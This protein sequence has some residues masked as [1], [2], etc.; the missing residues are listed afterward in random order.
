MKQW[1]II[2]K[3][4]KDINLQILRLPKQVN[5]MKIIHIEKNMELI[6]TKDNENLLQSQKYMSYY[7]QMNNNLNDCNSS[8]EAETSENSRKVFLKC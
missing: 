4:V 6:K 1:E 8:K 3:L 7:I 5:L 2:F